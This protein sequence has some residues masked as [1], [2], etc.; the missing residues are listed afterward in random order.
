MVLL[1][2]PKAWAVTIDTDEMRLG[3]NGYMNT[4][5]TYIGRMAAVQDDGTGGTAIGQAADVS[6]FENNSHLLI[7]AVTDAFRANL[8][9]EFHNDFAGEGT[10]AGS[11]TRGGLDILELFGQ[12]TFGSLF[13]VRSG[14]FLAPFGIYNQIRFFTP[15]FA[16]VVLPM[17]YAPEE[18]HV[19]E[20]LVP[21]NGNLMVMGGSS[22]DAMNLRYSLYMGNGQLGQTRRDRNKN[23]GVGVRLRGEGSALK[24]GGSYYTAVDDP[25]AE[26]RETLF[27][28]DVDF[29]IG[30]FNVQSEYVKD[31]AT[32][33]A[34]RLSYYTRLTYDAGSISPFIAYD[35]LEDKEDLLLNHGIQRY[36][37]GAGYAVNNNITLKAEYHYHLVKS[38]V[39]MMGA[40]DHNHVFRTAAIFI[41]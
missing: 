6:T 12:Y 8:N 38:D 18:V 7:N 25:L 39:G 30:R 17:M 1:A 24:I 28:M 4:H 29:S 36:S 16:P 13:E 33:H 35:Y 2:A 21:P 14:Y 31:D 40:P 37:T 27:G 5:Y 15:L 34:D 32:R 26:G 3:I 11:G 10:G 41:F 22:G 23:K 20:S 9:I 19:V